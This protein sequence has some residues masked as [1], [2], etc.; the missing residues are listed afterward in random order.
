MTRTI[1]EWQKIVTEY[2]INHE[3][4]WNPDEIDTMLL[5]LHS[6]VS[7]AS[8]DAR[9]NNIEHLGEELADIFIRLV[10]TAEVMGIDLEKE[11]ERKHAI[12]VARPVLHGHKRK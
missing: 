4:A 2:A 12:N 7:E 9:D 1:K 3:F 5:R 8:E 11:V 10:N 6:E